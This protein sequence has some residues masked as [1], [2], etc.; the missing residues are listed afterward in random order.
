MKADDYRC[1]TY[2]RHGMRVALA[3]LGVVKCLL[4]SMLKQQESNSKGNHVRVYAKDNYG[5]EWRLL[6]GWRR[7]R[8]GDEER[9]AVVE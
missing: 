6:P 9:R 4:Y 2:M 3:L 1:G 8:V 7:H 5:R